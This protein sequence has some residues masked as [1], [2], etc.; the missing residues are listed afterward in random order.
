MENVVALANAI[1]GEAANQSPE[2]MKMVG[3]TAINRLKSGR[4]HE[5]GASLPEILHKGYYAVSNPNIP[6]QQ[7]VTQKFPDKESETK[8]KQAMMIASGLIKGTITPDKG[9]FY[10]TN[11]EIG[12]LKRNPKKFNFKAVKKIGSSGDYQVFGY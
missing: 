2:V 3:S 6:Y 5:F 4:V 12:K 10:F 1:Y 11:K 7:A 8:F 9:E